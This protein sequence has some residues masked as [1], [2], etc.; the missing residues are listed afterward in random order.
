MGKIENLGHICLYVSDVERSK[1][2]YCGI[3]G[4]T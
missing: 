3:L 2:F 4:F 1:A